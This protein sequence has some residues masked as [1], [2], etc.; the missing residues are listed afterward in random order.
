MNDHAP[1]NTTFKDKSCLPLVDSL[2]RGLG[3]VCALGCLGLTAQT[4]KATL[5]EFTGPEGYTDNSSLTTNANWQV[6]SSSTTAFVVDTDGGGSV[7]ANLPDGGKNAF[8]QTSADFTTGNIFSDSVDFSFVQSATGGT[9]ATNTFFSLAYFANPT[10]TGISPAIAGFGRSG[11]ADG[12]RLA[13]FSTTAFSITGASIGINSG[14]GDLTSDNLRLTM[15]VQRGATSA[16]WLVTETLFNLSTST[17]IKTLTTAT[18]NVGDTI[19]A[20]SSLYA[21]IS[22]GSALATSGL[23][24]LTIQAFDTPTVVPEPEAVALLG[25]LGA[26]MLVARRRR[27]R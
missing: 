26:F 17:L 22:L 5:I 6:T 14:L 9:I 18:G 24:A 2:F 23:D 21:G 12:Y 15:T 7:A 20:D 27:N 19:H 13:A 3:A 4:A 16:T 11:V 25:G 1:L 8:Y 10:G